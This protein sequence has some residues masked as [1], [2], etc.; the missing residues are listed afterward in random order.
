MSILIPVSK[1]TCSMY[2]NYICVFV[3]IPTLTI[4]GIYGFLTGNPVI[5]AL[6]LITAFGAAILMEKK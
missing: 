6:G 5:I 4:G 1:R 2:G 3:S